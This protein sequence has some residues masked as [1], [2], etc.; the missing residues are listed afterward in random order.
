[1]A[2]DAKSALLAKIDMEERGVPDSLPS[3]REL[4]ESGAR[5]VIAYARTSDLSGRRNDSRKSAEGVTNQHTTNRN[6]ARRNS[7]VI[8]KRHTDNDLSASKDEY[9]PTSSR[10]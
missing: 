7:V 10:C 8:I 9:R 6:I 1:M 3:P 5:C 2:T 4:T